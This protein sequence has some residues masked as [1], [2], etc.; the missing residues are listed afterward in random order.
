MTLLLIYWFTKLQCP[1][2][3]VGGIY[4]VLNRR[5]GHVFEEN[6]VAGTPMFHV[7]AYLPVN[8]S[9]GEYFLDIIDFKVIKISW[10]KSVLSNHSR[11]PPE[12]SSILR[13]SVKA[14]GLSDLKE[15]YYHNLWLLRNLN[16]LFFQFQVSLPIWDPTLVVKLSHNVCLTI[17][18]LCKEIPWT[19]RVKPIKFAPTPKRGRAWRRVCLTW[20]IIWINYRRHRLLITFINDQTP[21][22][23]DEKPKQQRLQLCLYETHHQFFLHTNFLWFQIFSSEDKALL[24]FL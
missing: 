24:F 12:T 6:Q 22:F 2:N 17:G 14:L 16:W 15:K 7:K 19:S 20:P 1:E 10:W 5:R 23:S 8:E 9:F 21:R 13:I 11:F 4:G 18:K 3:A